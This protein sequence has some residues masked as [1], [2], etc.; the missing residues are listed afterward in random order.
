MPGSQG[1]AARRSGTAASDRASFPLCVPLW[2]SAENRPSAAEVI[3][4]GGGARSVGESAQ[5]W[6]IRVLQATP[7]ST[8]G[9]PATMGV[10]E[11]VERQGLVAL[12]ESAA[13]K[14]KEL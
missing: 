13:G 5:P 10:M 2:A 11:I 14:I 1:R 4:T 12:T 8:P 9:R 7:V 3:R 6:E